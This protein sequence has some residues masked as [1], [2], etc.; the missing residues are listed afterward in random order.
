[1]EENKILNII[2]A[3][4]FVSTI[5]IMA[6]GFVYLVLIKFDFFLI[7]F[8]LFFYAKNYY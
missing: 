4:L 8:Y 3:S 5:V 1:M 7:I 6:L 2:F